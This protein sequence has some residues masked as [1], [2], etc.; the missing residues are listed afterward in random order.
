MR[1]RLV[2]SSWSTIQTL[3]S[4]DETDCFRSYGVSIF[5]LASFMVSRAGR[6]YLMPAAQKARTSY[7]F[8]GFVHCSPFW[9]YD[10]E[11]LSKSYGLFPNVLRKI[12]FDIANDTNRRIEQFNTSIYI[13]SFLLRHIPFHNRETASDMPNHRQFHLDERSASIIPPHRTAPLITIEYCTQCAIEETKDDRLIGA[14]IVNEYK[15]KATTWVDGREYSTEKTL[16]E[17]KS[18]AA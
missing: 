7:L 8:R 11:R 12:Q 16:K 6:I 1:W 2:R 9:R 15:V 10:G 18:E 3:W 14:M 5:I 17:L 13:P 4:G